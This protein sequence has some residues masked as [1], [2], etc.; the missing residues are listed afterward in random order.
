MKI[1]KKSHFFD[2]FYLTKISLI[3]KIII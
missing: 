1:S 2:I 3:S